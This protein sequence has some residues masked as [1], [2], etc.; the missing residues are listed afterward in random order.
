[1]KFNILNKL[2]FINDKDII[3]NIF[4]ISFLLTH[5]IL[6]STFKIYPGY[7]F[8]YFPYHYTLIKIIIISHSKFLNWSS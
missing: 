7:K 2:S 3:I 5:Y 1:M 8:L 4:N 6:G